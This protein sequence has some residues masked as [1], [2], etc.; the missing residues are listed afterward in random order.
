MKKAQPTMS[1][2]RILSRGFD[3]ASAIRSGAVLIVGLAAGG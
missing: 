1:G 3:F 2:I